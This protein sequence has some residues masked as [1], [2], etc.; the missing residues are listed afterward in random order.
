MPV[1]T[2]IDD[3]KALHRRRAPRMFYDYAES[4]SYTEQ[5]FRENTEDFQ[6]IRFRQRVAVDMSGRNTA[7]TMLGEKVTMP[8]GL[9]PVGSTGM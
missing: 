5:T 4:G 6:K 9:A 2:C 1:I 3:L 8:V 7:S